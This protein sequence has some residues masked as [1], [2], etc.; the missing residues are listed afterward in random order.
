MRNDDVTGPSSGHNPQRLLPGCKTPITHALL[1]LLP[2]ITFPSPRTIYKNTSDC[3]QRLWKVSSLKILQIKR[4]HR[5]ANIT[6]INGLRS[7]KV[8]NLGVQEE[9]RDDREPLFKRPLH[10]RLET[11]LGERMLGIISLFE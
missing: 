8:E 4:P 6:L 5:L 10:G 2:A 7:S 11:T 1:F 9:P 3:G